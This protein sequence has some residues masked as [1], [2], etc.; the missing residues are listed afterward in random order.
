[1]RLTEHL[2]LGAAAAGL[3]PSTARAQQPDSTRQDTVVLAPIE[4]ISS[5]LPAA[6]PRIG[7]GIPAR[8]S[9]FSGREIDAWEPRTLADALGSRTGVSIYDDLGSPY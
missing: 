2:L 8:I 6:G 7:S 5:I 9:T 4:V 1:M 3:L